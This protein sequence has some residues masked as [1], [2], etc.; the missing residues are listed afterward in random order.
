[1]VLATDI[2]FFGKGTPINVTEKQ[3][4]ICFTIQAIGNDGEMTSRIYAVEMVTS[5]LASLML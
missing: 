4:K 3:L 1:M 2:K 5:I